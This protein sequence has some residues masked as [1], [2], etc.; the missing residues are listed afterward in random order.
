MFFFDAY[1]EYK[2]AFCSL[3]K[4]NSSYNYKFITTNPT[5]PTDYLLKIPVNLLTLDDIAL[6]LQASSHSQLPILE[7][8]I[9]YAKIF[10]S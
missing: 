6:L 10:S 1:G 7:R 5:E 4:I 3:N 9:K 8:S 2:N